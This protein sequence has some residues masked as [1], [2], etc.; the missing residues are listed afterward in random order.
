VIGRQLSGNDDIFVRV[1]D[2]LSKG[3]SLPNRQQNILPPRPVNEPKSGLLNLLRDNGLRPPYSASGCF[4]TTDDN[5][6]IVGHFGLSTLNVVCSNN[7]PPNG[8]H[9]RNFEKKSKST[10]RNPLQIACAR[11]KIFWAFTGCP[12]YQFPPS[13]QLIRP[14][15]GTLWSDYQICSD[16]AR[17]KS[18]QNFHHGFFWGGAIGLSRDS[19]DG[20]SSRL[21]SACSR[22]GFS[23]T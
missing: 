14:S 7:R 11:A 15:L 4:S 21:R 17:K 23:K 5:R 19:L 18:Y 3:A 22:C 9:H 16:G 8:F 6:N 10:F 20:G 2:L 12:V 1:V 13:A